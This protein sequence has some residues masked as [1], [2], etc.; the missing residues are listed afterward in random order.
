MVK[1]PVKMGKEV[2]KGNGTEHENVLCGIVRKVE[3]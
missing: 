1:T 2:N 3:I